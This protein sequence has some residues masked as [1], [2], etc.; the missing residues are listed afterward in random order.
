MNKILECAR[1]ALAIAALLGIASAVL[2]FAVTI[3]FFIFEGVTLMGILITAGI[4]G[5]IIFVISIA[6]AFCT[7][8]FD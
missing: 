6:V 8:Y 2:L 4:T 5:W 1:M 3:P 7:T